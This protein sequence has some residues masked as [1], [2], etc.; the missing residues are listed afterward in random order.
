M[1]DAAF[2]TAAKTSKKEEQKPAASLINEEDL[3]AVGGEWDG[4]DDLEID[5]NGAAFVFSF[6]FY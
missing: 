2:P 1:F 3:E 5:E 4:E 6:I